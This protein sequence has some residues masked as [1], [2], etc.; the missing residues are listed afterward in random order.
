VRAISSTTAVAA[1]LALAA[2]PAVAQ[3]AARASTSGSVRTAALI[4]AVAIQADTV[5]TIDG[6]FNEEVWRRALPA[7]GF[8][9]REPDEGAPTSHPTEVR[10]AFDTSSLYVAVRSVDPEP[11]A[12]VGMLTRRDEYSPS[13]R[14][15]VLIDSFGDRRTAYE[16]GVNVSGVKY[17][18]YWFNDTNNDQ[19]WD[20]VWDVGVVRTADGGRR[21]SA[22]AFRS[23]V[24]AA[25]NR[26]RLALPCSGRWRT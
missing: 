10:V 21:S 8:V 2:T 22:S 7:S 1:V 3:L 6:H 14:V 9:Q 24:S 15:A 16:F 4:D 12:L 25:G 19:G 23:C 5:M 17:D 18:R 26:E 13:D 11:G 20:A